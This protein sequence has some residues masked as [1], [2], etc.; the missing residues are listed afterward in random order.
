VYVHSKPIKFH[1]FETDVY[2]LFHLLIVIYLQR[3]E[4]GLGLGLGLGLALVFGLVLVL[5]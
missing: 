5:G 2:Y 3:D 1:L 4:L